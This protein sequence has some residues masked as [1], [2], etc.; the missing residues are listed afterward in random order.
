VIEWRID[1]GLR[2]DIVMYA[3]PNMAGKRTVMQCFPAGNRKGGRLE[4]SELKSMVIRAPLG[5]RVTLKCTTSE[6]WTE[7]PWRTVRLLAGHNV[8]AR[9]SGGMPGVRIPDLD[10]L[11][12]PSAR[13]TSRDLV[14]SY[15][16]ATADSD[17][18]TFGN[19]GALKGRVKVVE[20]V[21]E[22][23]QRPLTALEKLARSLLAA[24]PDTALPQVRGPARTALEDALRAEGHRDAARRADDLEAWLDAGRDA[25]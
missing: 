17:G 24:V 14:S 1:P 15:P 23:V 12:E 22:G 21:R 13:R 4:P 20:I 6:L 7:L 9:K 19:P 18:W 2:C 5:T 10:Q 11:D 8:P 25:D 16:R 3:A